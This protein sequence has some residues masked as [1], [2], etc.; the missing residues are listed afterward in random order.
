MLPGDVL[1]SLDHSWKEWVFD[2]R[3]QH[4]EKVASA[5]CQSSSVSVCRE[6]Q[7]AHG[8]EHARLLFRGDGSGVVDHMGHCGLRYFRSAGH[9]FHCCH[10]A[11][12]FLDS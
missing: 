4:A 7:F 8:E 12:P 2:V 11:S 6:A 3:D 9:I 5:K 10:A 1:E